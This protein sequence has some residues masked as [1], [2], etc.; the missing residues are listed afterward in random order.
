MHTL[1]EKLMKKIEAI[2]II[3]GDL[4][5][6]TKMPC[7]SFNLPAWECKTG[8][9]LAKIPGSVCYNCYAMKGNYTRFPVVKK[10]QYKKLGQIFN[11]AWVDAMVAMIERENNPFFRW[12]DA[13]DVQSVKHFNNICEVARKTPE[14]KHWLPTREHKII[15]DY[16]KAGN[17]I[18]DNLIVRIS[19]TM[20]D[21]KPSKTATHTSTVHNKS[22]PIGH[23]CPAPDQDGECGDCRACWDTNIKN[24]SYKEH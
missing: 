24:V 23:E 16:V 1:L 10:A 5:A 3:G 11:P 17:T 15:N 8:S 9:K 19:A 14:I 6:T 20:I 22:N 12:H 13:G 21:D 18:P 4:S 2:Q 7:K